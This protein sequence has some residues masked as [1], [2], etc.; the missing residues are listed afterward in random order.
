M[1]DSA[2]VLRREVNALITQPTTPIQAKLVTESHLANHRTRFE[3]IRAL[4]NA[5]GL[6]SP[7]VEGSVRR[8]KIASPYPTV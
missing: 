5:V 7:R 8:C 4:F 6:S 3:K 2:P 1:T